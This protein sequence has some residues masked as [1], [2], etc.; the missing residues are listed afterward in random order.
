MDANQFNW[1]VR[2][3]KFKQE[4]VRK[5][6]VDHAVESITI[7]LTKDAEEEMVKERKRKVLKSKSWHNEKCKLFISNREKDE[8]DGCFKWRFIKIEDI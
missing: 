1:Q 2:D 7:D 8:N 6:I 4:R 5:W 3:F